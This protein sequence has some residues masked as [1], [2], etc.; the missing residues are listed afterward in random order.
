MAEKQAPDRDRGD[1]IKY[2]R[3]DLLR[4]KSQ[5][6]FAEI[7]SAESGAP[8]TRGAIG[9]WELGKEVALKNL[10]LIAEVAGISLDWLAHNAGQKPDRAN[11]RPVPRTMAE[12]NIVPLVGYVRAG[13]SAAFYATATDPLDWV[14]PIGDMTKDT[15]AVQVQ[16]DSLGSFFDTWLIYYDEVR[17]PITPD[18]IGKLCVVGLMDDRVVVKT[19]RRSKTPGLF[20]LMSNTGQDDILDAEVIWAAKVK[21]MAPR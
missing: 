21:N 19:V 11:H 13:A 3:T 6:K 16:G 20:D 10:T 9:N 8:I 17:S 5:E 14:A 15:V 7:L 18:L 12:A 1:R 2:V 4:I